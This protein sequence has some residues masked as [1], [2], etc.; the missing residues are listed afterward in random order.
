[1]YVVTMDETA[2]EEEIFEKTISTARGVDIT[3]YHRD[4]EPEEIH[5]Y[6]NEAI[7][8]KGNKVEFRQSKAQVKYGA[9][10]LVGIKEGDFGIKMKKS[11]KI[12][13][14]VSSNPD[15]PYYRKDWKR[16]FVKKVHLAVMALGAAI[17]GGTE[18]IDGTSEVSSDDDEF[19]DLIDGIVKEE[20]PVD[21]NEDKPED[22][23][24]D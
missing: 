5:A 15:S 23:S 9:K 22:V 18:A 11:D 24:R 20:A 13:T 12:P 14:I 6:N 8:R 17:F 2:G 7:R 4:P 16:L 1:M 19:N 21:R 10:I 3:V